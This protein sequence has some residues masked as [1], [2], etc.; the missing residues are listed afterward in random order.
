MAN[1]FKSQNPFFLL[2]LVSASELFA[3]KLPLHPPTSSSSCTS[4]RPP[5]RICNFE[6]MP[7]E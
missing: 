3:V 7:D 2:M 6:M 1:A 4:Y 5:L